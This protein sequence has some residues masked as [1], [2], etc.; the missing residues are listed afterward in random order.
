MKK[1]ANQNHQPMNT[2]IFL[3]LSFL[4]ISANSQIIDSSVTKELQKNSKIDIVV[5]FKT[6]FN[7]DSL[8]SNLNS[9]EKS[10]KIFKE[11]NLISEKSQKLIKK[12]L[13]SKYLKYKSLYSPNCIFIYKIEKEIIFEILKGLF[14]E[15]SL[16][17]LNSKVKID[18]GNYKNTTVKSL[19]KD[20]IEWSIKAINADKLWEKGFKGQGIIVSNADTGIKWDHPA[21]RNSYQGNRNGSINHNYSW[22]DAL[23]DHIDDPENA[24]GYSL[25][26]PV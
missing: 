4:F 14:G 9:D 23:H 21:L 10:S 18:L 1:T 5:L 8:K 3:L 22:Y 16:I 20:Q 2:R 19:S 11:L 7:F 13:N 15:I 17:T 25:P 12:H 6:Q 26:Y 24:C